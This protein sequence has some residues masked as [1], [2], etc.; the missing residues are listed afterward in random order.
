M[1]KYQKIRETKINYLPT[2][3]MVSSQLCLCVIFPN[4]VR[5]R[6]SQ[7]QLF[8]STR[9]R[10]I[11]KCL[12]LLFCESEKG[13][14]DWESSKSM[15]LEDEEETFQGPRMRFYKREITYE[16]DQIKDLNLS[17]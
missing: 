3:C 15:S 1:I 5:D 8:S 16:S 2:Q 4:L 13:L 17:H 6:G 7:F 10:L 9:C 12:S 14:T 11:T